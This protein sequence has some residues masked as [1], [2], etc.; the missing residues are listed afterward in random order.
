LAHGAGAGCR[1]LPDHDE[2]ALLPSRCGF[3]SPELYEFLEAE[4]YGYVIRL[5]AN[6]VLQRRIA[7]LLK[8]PVGRPPHPVR[9]FHASFRYQAQSWNRSRRVVAKVKWTRLS[10]RSIKA[11]AVRLQL[12]ALAYNLANFFRPLVLPDEVER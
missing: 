3:A 10:C 8:R 1:S 9:C 11:N 6:A 7:H 2:A 12:H 4:G 5:P